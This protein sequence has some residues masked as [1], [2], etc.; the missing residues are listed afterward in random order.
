ME[1]FQIQID[2]IILGGKEAS[3]QVGDI[4][5][6]VYSKFEAEGFLWLAFSWNKW[7]SMGYFFLIYRN[8]PLIRQWLML[9]T[10]GIPNVFTHSGK[11][12]ITNSRDTYTY[13]YIL[14]YLQT[15]THKTPSIY[16]LALKS[17]LTINNCLS[18]L[19]WSKDII[20][21]IPGN[22]S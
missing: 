14:M 9:C 5:K 20:Q 16:P 18:W 17:C 11:H 12:E 2:L 1:G 21:W 7:R 4:K 3:E 8:C 13:W 10:S 6:K 22:K 19:C 15:H